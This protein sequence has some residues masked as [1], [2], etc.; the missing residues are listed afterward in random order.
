[1][2]HCQTWTAVGCDAGRKRHNNEDYALACEPADSAICDSKGCLYVVADGI[3]GGPAGEVA[4]QFAVHSVI[5]RFY[6]EAGP[7]QARLAQSIAGANAAIH[8]FAREHPPLAH[9][10]TTIVAVARRDDSLCIAHVG[11]SRAYLLHDGG[12]R[13]LTEDHNLAAVLAREQ[14]LS[15][16]D[17]PGHP[18]R[19]LLLRSLGAEPTVV[20]D[21]AEAYLDKGDV[22]LLCSDG[23]TRHVS[24]REFAVCLRR[25]TPDEAASALI[26]LA[27][28]RGGEDNIAVV[29]VQR[30]EL[31]EH[32]IGPGVLN[33]PPPA[34]DIYEIMEQ[35]R[36]CP[37]RRSTPA[38]RLG[39]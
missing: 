27:N 25:K 13:R 29:I 11:D 1:M 15:E 34:P 37:P 30:A 23:L 18:Y 22:L 2:D 14:S 32:A 17:A 38:R 20:P 6:E 9:M 39:G 31:D 3:G 4:S 10:G 26:A 24:D 19:N 28:E 35:A 5:H 7:P 33:Q 36:K 12:V 8:K 21:F 16:A